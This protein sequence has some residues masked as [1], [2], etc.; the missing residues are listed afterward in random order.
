MAQ[1][2]IFRVHQFEKVEQFVVTSPEGDESKKMQEEMIGN[3]KEFYQSLG[4]PYR[5]VNMVSGALNDA[6]A[7]KCGAHPRSMSPSAPRGLPDLLH[8]P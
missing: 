7:K 2:G 8:H 5:V 4:I 1:A 6:A 3:C